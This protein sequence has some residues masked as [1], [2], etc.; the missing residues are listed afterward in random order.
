LN[1]R[2]TETI[3]LA[4]AFVIQMA[5]IPLGQQSNSL[6]PFLTVQ[7]LICRA[8][9]SCYSDYVFEN[10]RLQDLVSAVRANLGYYEEFIAFLKQA[11]YDSLHS[12]IAESS[13]QRAVEVLERYLST[14]S[15]ASLYDGLRRPYVWRKAR[16]YFIAWVFRDAPAQR[17][18]PLLS[19]VP[20][21]TLA[22]RRAKLLNEVRKFVGSLL[23]EAEHWTWP[24]ISEVM[25]NRLE[26]SRRALH[27]IAYQ[28]I[29]RDCLRA[30]FDNCGLDLDVKDTELRLGSETYDVVI[31]GKHGTILV[32][33][34]TRE[35]MG[36]GHS[37]LFARDITTPVA[38]AKEHGYKCVPIIVAEEWGGN[39]KAVD[40]ECFIHIEANPNERDLVLTR[41]REELKD[42]SDVFRAIV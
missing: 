1:K 11:G 14:P 38:T 8:I 25:L 3:R 34:K 37:R 40:A 16:W 4:E 13:D 23:P 6:T 18:G 32:P 42:I 17:L 15:G 30:V 2:K 39:M 10:Y 24:T 35:T 36:G 27:G 12:F 19:R 5:F 31:Q 29:V 22:E 26:G 7:R 33:V 20:G 9:F 21:K 28:S 41:L